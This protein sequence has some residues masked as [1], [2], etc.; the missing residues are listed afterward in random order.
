M[1]GKAIRGS[2]TN[3]PGASTEFGCN[4]V[5]FLHSSSEVPKSFI[6]Q[7]IEFDLGDLS[8]NKCGTVFSKLK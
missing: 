5:S 4:V 8:K 6:H 2:I 3:L 7:S 1:P